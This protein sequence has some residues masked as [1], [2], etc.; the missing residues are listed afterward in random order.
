LLG[1]VNNGQE[2]RA[3][4]ARHAEL[5]KHKPEAIEESP[6]NPVGDLIVI[7]ERAR[8]WARRRL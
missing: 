3:L 2:V 8:L 7:A 5:V 6:A 4:E 1:A